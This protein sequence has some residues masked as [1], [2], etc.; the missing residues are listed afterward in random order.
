M[1]TDNIILI[2]L[3]KKPF[4]TIKIMV[5]YKYVKSIAVTFSYFQ[6]KSEIIFTI[7]ILTTDILY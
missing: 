2:L 5:S 7:T 6:L 1:E 4:M 3:I